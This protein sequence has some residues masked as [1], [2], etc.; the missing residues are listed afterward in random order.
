[1]T[2]HPKVA[3]IILNYNGFVHTKECLDSLRESTYKPLMIIV[4]DNASTDDSVSNLKQI[5]KPDEKLIELSVNG[6]YTYGNNAGIDYA[7]RNGAYY[8]FVINND[9][10]VDRNCIEYLIEAA[11]NDKK[12]GIIGPKVLYYSQPD[13][14]NYV[15]MTGDISAAKY[16]RIGL[17][18]KDE[19]QYEDLVD[20][21]YQDGC[22]LM[23]SKAC[24]E[25]VGGFDELLWTYSEETD[26]CFRARKAGFR[27]CCQQKAKI[28]HKVSAELGQHCDRKP[29]AEY[30]IVR[31]N[32]IFHRRYS[33]STLQ[34]IGIITLLLRQTPRRLAAIA[35]KGKRW[36]LKNIWMVII[37]TLIGIMTNCQRPSDAFAP[38]KAVRRNKSTYF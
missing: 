31:N 3:V 26:L 2:E 18:E 10:V 19:G 36:R 25:E 22:A 20:T 6:G 21:F 16:T 27:I 1:M 23:I 34:K 9:T 37:A 33:D 29:Y 8:V 4:V 7:F 30:Y 15:G 17:N 38:I 5:L 35:I 14:I 13:T 12:I 24:Y 32:Y 11:L 28:W